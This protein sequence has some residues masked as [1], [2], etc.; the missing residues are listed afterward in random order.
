M[1]LRFSSSWENV[2]ELVELVDKI[3]EGV[4]EVFEM[5]VEEFVIVLIFSAGLMIL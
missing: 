1:Y 3:D 4:A 2:G 5:S